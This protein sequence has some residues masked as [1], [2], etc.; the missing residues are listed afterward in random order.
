MRRFITVPSACNSAKTYIIGYWQETVLNK[1]VWN[2]ILWSELVKWYD[3]LSDQ[4]NSFFYRRMNVRILA[5]IAFAFL[6]STSTASADELVADLKYYKTVKVNFNKT[7]DKCN[8]TDGKIFAERV[9]QGVLK[10]GFQKDP[11]SRMIV[12]LNVASNSFG[13]LGT[14]CA[15][16]VSLNLQTYLKGEEVVT[17]NPEARLILDRFIEFPISVYRTGMFG[18]QAQEEP[19]AG[20]KST[21]SRDAVF[22]MIDKIMEDLNKARNR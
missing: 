3:E 12:L 5:A 7:A 20:G 22:V 2:K 14:Q 4:R 15:T 17:E 18:V 6:I 11:E 21:A 10:S 16:T 9:E 1:G 13:L 19:S 8:L